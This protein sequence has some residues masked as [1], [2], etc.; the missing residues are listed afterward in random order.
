MDCY[1]VVCM[2]TM[3]VRSRHALPDVHVGLALQDASLIAASCSA[4]RQ[5]GI[6]VSVHKLMPSEP[7][8]QHTAPP[9]D[10]SCSAGIV[11]DAQCELQ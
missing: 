4:E 11:V 1:E 6:A 9:S 5:Y 7:P 10:Y 2:T 3:P 8:T